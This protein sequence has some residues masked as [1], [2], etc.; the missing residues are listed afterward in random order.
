MALRGASFTSPRQVRE[1]IDRFVAAYN[2]QAA[3]FEWQK[4]EVH[5]V[6]HNQYYG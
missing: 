5:C 3:P 4:R 6:G 2:V 1:A